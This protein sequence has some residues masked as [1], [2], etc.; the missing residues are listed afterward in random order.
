MLT[1]V[2]AAA[3]ILTVTATAYMV[4]PSEPSAA[5]A[6]HP[7]LHPSPTGIGITYGPS[8]SFEHDY[9]LSRVDI[10]PVGRVVITVPI[11]MYH[12]IR[13]PPPIRADSLGFKLSISPTEFTAQ[14]DSLWASGYHA[15]DL[16]DIRAYFAGRQPLPSRPVVITFDDG[17]ADLFTT[18]YPILAKHHFKAVAYIVSSFVGRPGY[19][20]ADQL[21]QLDHN[22][23]EIASHTV[24]H[25]DLARSSAGSRMQELV[26]SKRWLEQLVGH[27][28]LDFAYP[29][30]KFN[31][32]VVSEVQMAGYDTAVT[33]MTS[34][35]HSRADR[36]VWTRVRVG[37]GESL[38][39]FTLSLGTPMPS[40]TITVLEIE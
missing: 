39:D 15:V 25:P 40:K 34:V 5:S 31:P 29:S 19:V 35:D 30:G 23:I 36:Y 37:G 21:L 10:V 27:P 18:A 20:T 13:Q 4:Q 33:T 7:K 8:P 14:V 26:D 22:G 38:T 11:L 2:R 28:V 12:Y 9:F 6:V 24:D 16:N 3:L 32:Q 1:I 17:Y